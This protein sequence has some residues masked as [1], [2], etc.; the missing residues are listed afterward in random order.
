M[1]LSHQPENV[2]ELI[3]QL[4]HAT[5]L[6]GKGKAIKRTFKITNSERNLVS[7]KFNEWDYGKD[8]IKLPCNARGLFSLEDEPVLAVRGYDKFFN[9]NEV[10]I[11]RW[12]FL[13]EKTKGPYYVTSKENGCII[14]ISGLQDGTLI[15]CSKHSTGTRED[16]DRN[17]AISG[18][19]FLIKQLASKG[20]TEKEFALELYGMNVTAVCEYCDDGFEEHIVEYKGESSGLYLHGLNI[21]KPHFETLPFEEV[22]S[23]SKKF[24]FKTISYF[25]EQSISGLKDTLDQFSK[26]GSY[27][28]K[29]IEGF[30]IRCKLLDDRDYFFKFK[31]E[32]PYLMYR[33]WREVT[34]SYIL[35]KKRNEI[36]INKHKFITNKYLD[37][38]IPIIDSNQEIANDFLKGFGQIDLRQR[39]L[40]EYGKSGAEILNQELLEE[41]DALNAFDKLKIDD[42]SKFVFVPIATIGCGKTTTSLTLTNLYPEFDLV[43]NDNIPKSKTSKDDFIKESLKILKTKKAVILDRN[44]HQFRERQQIFDDISKFRDD[45]LPYDTN[46][47]FIALNFIDDSRSNKLWEITTKRVYERGDNHQSIKASTDG[48]KKVKSIMSGFVNRFQ[49][50]DKN[51]EPDSKF[52]YIVNLHVNSEGSSFTNAISIINKI[53]KKY[54]ILIPNLPNNEEV[55]LSFKKALEYKPTFTKFISKPK[56]NKVVYFSAQVTNN[57]SLLKELS[58]L[59]KSNDSEEFYNRLQTIERLQD[60]FHV[61]LSHINQSKKGTDFEKEVWK[62]WK[63]IYNRLEDPTKEQTKKLNIKL[64]IQLKSVVFDDKALAIYIAPLK[65]ID[66]EGNRLDLQISNKF[67]HITIGTIN[68]DIKPYYSNS[69]LQNLEFEGY[70]QG[71]FDKVTILNW[72]DDVILND[73]EVIAN[74]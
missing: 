28:G 21:N 67:P 45:F 7:W 43:I 9:I 72:D 42:E 41:L 37:F 15:V 56:N 71:K 55:K 46:I 13:Q 36:K 2:R 33:Q 58:N 48:T 74:C 40:K 11:T 73:L 26:V 47:Q 63:K 14:L 24:G 10:P 4:E 32:E 59:L 60:E 35:S 27:Q 3:D 66:N 51:K 20:V 61:T 38:V 6:K 34:R 39:F 65:F 49:G 62:A 17:H 57:T 22:E 23:F 1:N 52:D 54:P 19:G 50:I 53:H 70:K 31:F 8:K 68:K 18:Q 44:N 12:E 29:E 5:Q 64:T 16:V 30:V 69:L 25:T